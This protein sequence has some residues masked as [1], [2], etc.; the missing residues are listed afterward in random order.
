MVAGAFPQCGAD[1][2]SSSDP[3]PTPASC[4]HPT[5]SE[6]L[7]L[8]QLDAQLAAESDAGAAD[9]GPVASA[10]ASGELG[11]VFLSCP[12]AD[13]T[14]S[15]RGYTLITATN[16]GQY[17]AP[18][19]ATS[20]Q[21]CYGR[22]EYTECLGGRPFIVDG[23]A[24]V[25]ET[26]ERG[27]WLAAAFALPPCERGLRAHLAR[28]WLADAL[29]E[30]ASVA[31][32]AR[33]ALDL[34]AL[35]APPELIAAAQLASLDEIEHARVCFSLASSYGAV[36]YGPG[37]LALGDLR[38]ARDSSELVART[39]AEGC[40]GETIAALVVA[41]QARNAQDPELCRALTRIAAD[42]AQHAELAWQL[43]RWAIARGGPEVR[44]AARAAF[45][46]A[47]S[48]A[49]SPAPESVTLPEWLAHGRLG[50]V[51]QRRVIREAH[52]LVI[53]PC[54]WALFEGE[55]SREQVP[56]GH[57]QKPLSAS[58]NFQVGF[59]PYGQTPARAR[60]GSR[61]W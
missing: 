53:S 25:A 23:T 35:G 54:A 29:A 60:S 4:Y 6:C 30:H 55:T 34:L 44:A 52:E 51:E 39:I 18:P 33:L 31:A 36:P 38:G 22:V 3:N 37:T 9:A 49:E 21:C 2:R 56:R 24:R 10:G 14:P 13:P 20:A 47:S 17:A 19:T 61:W 57:I 32:F 16:Q 27:D 8:A 1:S 42:E 15:L 28:A 41:E 11:P 26:T 43:V 5:L 50:E 48:P 12:S 7:T 59:S 46:H 45:E 58:G 40:V